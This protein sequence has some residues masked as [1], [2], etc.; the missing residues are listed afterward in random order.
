MRDWRSVNRV[1]KQSAEPCLQM[2]RQQTL[3]NRG[4]GDQLWGDFSEEE[5]QLHAREAGIEALRAQT[6]GVEGHAADD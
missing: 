3:L 2:W 4:L 6:W 1:K 5:Q